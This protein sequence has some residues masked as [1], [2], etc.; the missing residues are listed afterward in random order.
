MSKSVNKFEEIFPE[1][2]T[3]QFSYVSSGSYAHVYRCKKQQQQ[4]QEPKLESSYTVID[5]TTTTT[6][7]NST[8]DEPQGP[9]E[10]DTMKK[11]TSTNSIIDEQCTHGST[12]IKLIDVYSE[13]VIKNFNGTSGRSSVSNYK[14]AYNEFKISMYLAYLNVGIHQN[15]K[16]YKC[17]TF[18]E[19]YGT[20]VAN[21]C[22]P[23][24]FDN[25]SKIKQID[26]GRLLM[27]RDNDENGAGAADTTESKQLRSRPSIRELI[28]IKPEIAIIKMED[29]G[30]PI[31][32]ILSRLNP[33][34]ILSLA[35]Q[36]LLG[37]MIAEKVYEF[38]H[39][40][41]HLG[42]IM[43]KRCECSILEYF[44]N[45]KLI[46]VPSEELQAKVIDTTFSRLKYSK[47]I[48]I[49]N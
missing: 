3:E 46:T 28:T 15:D 5:S 36:L 37:F 8:N 4:Q 30:V 16:L 17:A 45:D 1:T 43:V 23:K 6:N 31:I 38:E 2:L 34:Q 7:T 10:S 11:Q 29:C 35:K 19:V 33:L 39:R 24:Y 26:Y 44:Y 12:V 48:L 47:F 32:D 27:K 25:S 42:N 20:Y 18:P 21:N 40:D 14:D 41:L 22:I 13:L 9:K 49:Y